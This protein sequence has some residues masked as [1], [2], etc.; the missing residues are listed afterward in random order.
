M[1]FVI[2]IDEKDV[3]LLVKIAQGIGFKIADPKRHATLPENQ[4]RAA[5]LLE[6]HTAVTFL[7]NKFIS[8]ITD[9]VL[10]NVALS[11]GNKK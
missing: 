5:T 9:K 8:N 1:K 3:V 11:L 6:N 4:K 7:I 2:N 10:E